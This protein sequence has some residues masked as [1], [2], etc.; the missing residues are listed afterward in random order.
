MFYL[1][2]IIVIA[3]LGLLLLNEQKKNKKLMADKEMQLVQCA[4][5]NT[6]ITKSEANIKNGICHCHDCLQK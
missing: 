4:K 5:C 1:L 2:L 3:L 6:Y